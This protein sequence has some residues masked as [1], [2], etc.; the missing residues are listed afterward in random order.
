MHPVRTTIA[1]VRIGCII[2]CAVGGEGHKHEARI[3]ASRRDRAR[4]WRSTRSWITG[5]HELALNTAAAVAIAV[6]VGEMKRAVRHR[7]EPRTLARLSGTFEGYLASVLANSAGLAVLVTMAIEDAL[8]TD[9]CN[10]A[11]S[12]QE[13]QSSLV[14]SGCCGELGVGDLATA[15]GHHGDMNRVAV[16][17]HPADHDAFDGGLGVSSC[18]AG[19]AFLTGGGSSRVGQ[20]GQ[21]GGLWP[22]SY[23]VMIHPAGALGTDPGS[24]TGQSKDSPAG[25]QSVIESRPPGPAYHYDCR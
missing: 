22:G 23:E 9:G 4:W 3:E 10:S 1:I 19:H 7:G 12:G 20:T 14:S 16:G 24:R 25:R 5:V 21:S 18:H 17:V 11:V 6:F 15:V 2:Y 13:S 8:H